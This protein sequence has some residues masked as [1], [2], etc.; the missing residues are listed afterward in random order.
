MR[1]ERTKVFVNQS[2][3][4]IRRMTDLND[5]DLSENED[6]ALLVYDETSQKFVATKSLDGITIDNIIIQGGTF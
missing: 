6:G 3:L 5:V 4:V 1:R 2:N